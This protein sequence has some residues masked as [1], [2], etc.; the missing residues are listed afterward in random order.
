METKPKK[1]IRRKPAV[2]TE[3]KDGQ[4][5]N[6]VILNENYTPE[7]RA[8]HSRVSAESDDWKTITE[9]D[10]EDFSLAEDPFK[11]PPPA[12][13]LRDQ[14]KFAFRWITRSA[15]RLDQMKSK[16][17]PFRWWP[18][19]RMQPMVGAMDAFIDDNNGCI[20]REDQ[21]LVFKP[22]WMFEKELEYKRQLA[23]GNSGD[24]A[25]KNR[26]PIGDLEYRSGKRSVN[27]T[28]SLREEVKGSDVQYQG[29]AEMDRA[30]GVYTPEVGDSDLVVNE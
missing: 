15:S 20:S 26:T 27:D 7:E 5:D 1:V 2:H 29:E 17:V 6:V 22:Y 28:R 12:A 14:R 25:S 16:V 4:K 9:A 21:M 19:N 18:V 8:I 24:V 3:P 23:D 10:M 13:K 11:L 30:A